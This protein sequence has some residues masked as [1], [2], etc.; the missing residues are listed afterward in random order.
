MMR[1]SRHGRFNGRGSPHPNVHAAQPLA[2]PH[3]PCGRLCSWNAR[4]LLT[5]RAALR[6]QKLQQLRELLTNNDIV[7]LQGTHGTKAE[8]STAA[9]DVSS[10]FHIFGRDSR[11]N[12]M[13]T[14][15]VRKT[16]AEGCSLTYHEAI[17]GR[18]SFLYMERDER[19]LVIANLHLAKLD[20]P[21]EAPRVG[22]LLEEERK[23]A[24]ASR[25]TRL[26]CLLGDLNFEATP[27]IIR[28]HEGTEEHR[29]PRH[30]KVS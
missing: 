11:C 5:R 27:T 24:A 15:L 23:V 26:F 1:L 6:R 3:T 9:L 10:T 2:I 25:H 30:L 20:T 21:T 28:T 19:K 14:P 8:L 17:D 16:W 12:G 18:L 7:L 22:R 4:G 13:V 29:T